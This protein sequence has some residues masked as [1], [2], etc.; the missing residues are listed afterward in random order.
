MHKKSLLLYSTIISLNLFLL[1]PVFFTYG[2]LFPIHILIYWI[3]FSRILSL[4]AFA[5]NWST[6]KFAGIAFLIQWL[7]AAVMILL[8]NDGNMD[9]LQFISLPIFL[10]FFI[11]TSIEFIVLYFIYNNYKTKRSSVKAKG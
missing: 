2:I 6:Q 10:I 7:F 11:G 4:K 8:S 1:L 5:C 3:S 9:L